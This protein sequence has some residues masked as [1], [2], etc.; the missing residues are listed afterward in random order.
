MIN[1][2]GLSDPAKIETSKGEILETAKAF[3]TLTLEYLKKIPKTKLIN[4]S[5]GIVYGGQFSS[6]VKNTNLIDENFKVNISVKSMNTDSIINE[7][8]FDSDISDIRSVSGEIIVDIASVFELE[9]SDT[10]RK[11]FKQKVKYT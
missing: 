7:N 6:A 1:C 2:V 11:I 3:D 8:S 10:L 9:V 5:S 4:F